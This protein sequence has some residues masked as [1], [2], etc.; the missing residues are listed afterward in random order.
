VS[1]RRRHIVLPLLVAGAL[2]LAGAAAGAVLLLSGFM[3][4]AATR[5]HF[6]VTHRLLEAGLTRSIRAHVEDIKVPRLDDPRLVDVGLACYRDHCAQC[7]GGPGIAPG[8]AALGL[9]PIPASLAQTARE[10][11]PESLYY[12]TSKGVRMTG[13]PAWELRLSERSLWATV[14]FMRTLPQLD[15]PQYRQRL[16]AL[17]AACEPR[18]DLPDLPREELGDIL[19]RQYGCHACHVIDGVVGPRSFTGPPLRAWPQ[20]GYI[21]GV[22]PNTP[23]NLARFI[24]DPQAISPA[25]LMPDLDVPPSHAQAMAAFLFA[26]R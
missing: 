16:A 5:Q 6:Y 24:R 13:M 12:V 1:L 20:R 8:P 2:L 9:L 25:T 3:T 21:A 22:L 4:T 15:A 17:T 7:H 19:L 14:A 26:Q 23:A 18:T 10:W 11:P